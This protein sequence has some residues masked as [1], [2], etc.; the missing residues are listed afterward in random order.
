A[1]LEIAGVLATREPFPLCI[2]EHIELSVGL[3]AHVLCGGPD[4]LLQRRELLIEQAVGRV[5]GAGETSLVLWIG[6]RLLLAIGVAGALDLALIEGKRRRC[7][8]QQQDGKRAHY[9]P[10]WHQRRRKL[11]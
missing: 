1:V 2:F 10:P 6:A 8:E 9:S 4:P 5:G 7:E 11:R 3:H